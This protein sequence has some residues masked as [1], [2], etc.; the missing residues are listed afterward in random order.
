MKFGKLDDISEVDFSL[1]PDPEFNVQY[2]NNLPPVDSMNVY[3]GA[4]GWTTRSWRGRWY[5]E[6]TPIKNFLE[7]YGHQFNSIELNTTYYNTPKIST[8]E[9]WKHSVPEDFL[10]CPKVVK[11][12][13][14]KKDLGVAGDDIDRLLDSMVHLGTKLGSFFLQLPPSFS[15]E[16]WKVLEGF[17]NYFPI[18]LELAI[19]LRHES[20]FQDKAALNE[21]QDL[22]AAKNKALLITDVAGRRD[23]LHMRNSTDYMMVRWVGNKL[24]KTDYK[25]IDQW[26]DRLEY[27]KQQG[28]KKAYF[29][30]HEPDNETVPE[31]THYFCQKLMEKNGFIVRGP[32]PL[33]EPGQMSLF[34]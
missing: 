31:I 27:L 15:T 10:F 29:F 32:K 34:T 18:D 24:H 2:F 14:H 21:L 5:P 28:V 22:A 13:A 7:A 20:W 9:K 6:K 26:V 3:V 8:L 30:L 25:R 1:P 19:E 23:V 33:A 11:W 12:I 4:T 16:K 17:L